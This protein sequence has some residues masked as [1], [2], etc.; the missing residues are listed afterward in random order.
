M[1]SSTLHRDVANYHFGI[2]MHNIPSQDV[3]FPYLQLEFI[4]VTVKNQNV[5]WQ[6]LFSTPISFKKPFLLFCI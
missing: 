3:A 1:C 5:T 4:Y 2:H 6:A